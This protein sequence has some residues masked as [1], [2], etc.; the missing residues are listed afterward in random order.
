M[1]SWKGFSGKPI[2]VGW[3]ESGKWWARRVM[4]DQL[5]AWSTYLGAAKLCTLGRND[6]ATWSWH[7]GTCN[8]LRA[9]NFGITHGVR[10]EDRPTQ[11]QTATEAVISRRPGAREWTNTRKHY[12]IIYTKETGRFSSHPDRVA[13]WSKAPD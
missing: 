10:G 7:T 2:V 9:Q 12:Y 5:G 13:E 8:Q 1:D 6:D 4:K 11:S 3:S